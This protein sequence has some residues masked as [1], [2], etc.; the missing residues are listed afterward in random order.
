MISRVRPTKCSFFLL[1]SV[2]RKAASYSEISYPLENLSS[3]QA[4]NL[5]N[6]A[7]SLRQAFR[8]PSISVLFLMAFMELTKEGITVYWIWVSMRVIAYDD[9]GVMIIF[10]NWSLTSRDTGAWSR[11]LTLPSPHSRF[12]RQL[13]ISSY[14]LVSTQSVLRYSLISSAS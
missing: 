12:L 3:S 1:Y 7:L 2:R 5:T 14:P 8:I 13:Q 6:E 10:R 11:K 9:S 4:R